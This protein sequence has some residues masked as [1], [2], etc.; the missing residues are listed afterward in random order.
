MR[1][2]FIIPA[3]AALAWAPAIGQV[4]VSGSGERAGTSPT[5]PIGF[6]VLRE[7][8]DPY[9]GDHWFLLRDQVHPGGPGRLVRATA[10]H[11]GEPGTGP[12]PRPKAAI[13]PLR[14]VI[15]A[16]DRLI[17]EEHT[18]VADVFLE[19]TA[20]ASSPLAVPFNARMRMGGRVVRVVALA[21]GRAVFE[22]ETERLP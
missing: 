13:P 20:L 1:L 21:P 6:Q 17:V 9:S 3:L 19:A 10:D 8:D 15:H 11:I 2:P 12:N 14:P 4:G 16:G 18:A 7:I 5:A 22:P